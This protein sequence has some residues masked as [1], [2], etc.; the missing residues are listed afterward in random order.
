M[1]TIDHAHH[2]V[3]APRVIH[4]RPEAAPRAGIRHRSTETA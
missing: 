2:A 3:S 1:E 4:R